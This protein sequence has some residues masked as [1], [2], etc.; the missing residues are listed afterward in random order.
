MRKVS[1]SEPLL[2]IFVDIPG[3]SFL[4]LFPTAALYFLLSRPRSFRQASMSSATQWPIFVGVSFFGSYRPVP[5]AAL[6][7]PRQCFVFR[8]APL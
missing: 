8:S 6:C 1:I 5:M 4:P 3:V 7:F 2:E